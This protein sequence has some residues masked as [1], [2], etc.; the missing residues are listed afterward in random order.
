MQQ[1]ANQLSNPFVAEQLTRLA[2]M[3]GLPKFE[4]GL[5]FLD[6]AQ[7]M[8]H[9]TNNQKDG[10]EIRCKGKDQNPDYS[11]I[12]DS[13]GG[14]HKV[15]QADASEI[16]PGNKI[17]NGVAALSREVVR[18]LPL[19]T[20]QSQML[21]TDLKQPGLIE[22]AAHL[23]GRML[24]FIAEQLDIRGGELRIEHLYNEKL[25]IL[26]LGESRFRTEN[27][28]L[29]SKGV[30]IDLNGSLVES[31]T[32]ITNQWE[33]FSNETKE[34]THIEIQKGLNFLKTIDA[35]TSRCEL[36]SK[37]LGVPINEVDCD[38]EH[39]RTEVRGLDPEAKGK[40]LMEIVLA[41]RA[42]QTPARCGFT[43]VID[44]D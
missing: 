19:D 25:Y 1:V 27:I 10:I 31:L 43:G 8:Y 6:Y 3:P 24:Q 22:A 44:P 18:R 29:G 16:L 40:R 26:T 37:S 23:K 21:L 11:F 36:F 9:S 33:I 13:E 12:F 41:R 35:F 14:L 38:I 42:S 5:P 4:L 32:A 17:W 30:L 39:L 28:R 20:E 7:V 34:I 2:D 15:R